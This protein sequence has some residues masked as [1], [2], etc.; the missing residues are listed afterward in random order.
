MYKIKVIQPQTKTTQHKGILQI[1]IFFM[2][3]YFIKVIKIPVE[4]DPSKATKP[5][6]ISENEKCIFSHP[7]S[8]SLS[9]IQF[10]TFKVL[11]SLIPKDQKKYNNTEM[12]S[13]KSPINIRFFSI[14]VETRH[15]VSRIVLL[16]FF[17]KKYNYS[18]FL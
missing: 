2:Y 11:E 5:K 14:T 13:Y 16:F 12:K 1:Y 9:T 18:K 8:T 17:L 6:L 10:T 7:P 15:Q 4:A 3:M